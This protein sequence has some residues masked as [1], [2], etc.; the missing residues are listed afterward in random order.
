LVLSFFKAAS[1][2]AN[3]IPS[4]MSFQTLGICFK[5]KSALKPGGNFHHIPIHSQEVSGN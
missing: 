5:G 3:V 2:H 1:V 4:R